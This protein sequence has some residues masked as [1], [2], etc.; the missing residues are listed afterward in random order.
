MALLLNPL[1]L[2]LLY[3]YLSDK[4]TQ[5]LCEVQRRYAVVL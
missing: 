1:E 2:L 3:E 4:D 5:C